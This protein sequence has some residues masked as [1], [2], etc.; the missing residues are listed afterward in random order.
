MPD[1]TPISTRRRPLAG[2][3]RAGAAVAGLGL[4]VVA[5]VVAGC[6]SSGRVAVGAA[7]T[8]TTPAS[9]APASTT[10]AP[11]TSPSSSTAPAATTAPPTAPPATA[12]PATAPPATAPATT[13]PST[14]GSTSGPC[15]ADQLGANQVPLSAGT[16]QYYLA[17][18]LTNT[19]SVS[20]VVA[21]GRP[22]VQLDDHSG[23]PVVAYTTTTL[24][25]G[26]TSALV[27]APKRSVWFLT[28]ESSAACPA[29][30]TVAGGPFHYVLALPGGSAQ[31]TW[32]PSYLAGATLTDF[33]TRVLLSVGPLQATKPVP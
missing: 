25:G 8:T 23:Q 10:S 21:A 29:T 13:P 11:P 1:A 2:R 24:P 16:G 19:S 32:S 20:C 9:S 31:V 26:S 14:A 27:V 33:C 30:T 22:S 5:F 17:W 18:S 4:G 7:S 6:G 12:A 28:E 15:R 3:L